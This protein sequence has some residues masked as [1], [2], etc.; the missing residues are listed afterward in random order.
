[1]NADVTGR[2][3]VVVEDSDEDY[4]TLRRALAKADVKNPILRF[5]RGEEALE[6]LD[7]AGAAPAFVI[8]DLNLPGI[9]GRVVLSTLKSDAKLK[10]I[11]VVVLTT[12]DN[13]VDVETCYRSGA[14][15]YHLKAFEFTRF[16]E[17]VRV[18]ADFWL[19]ATILPAVGSVN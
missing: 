12:S 19:D 7:E 8:L 10:T 2:S 4:F 6:H 14:N 17:T 16:L 3:I 5:S 11:P 13:P 15:S 18:I 9:D 1:M